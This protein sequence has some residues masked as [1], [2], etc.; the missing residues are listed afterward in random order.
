PWVRV[1]PHRVLLALG[2]MT[3]VISMWISNTTATALM[4]PVALGLLATLRDAH[5]PGDGMDKSGYPI[6]M[7]LTLSY[8]ATAGG[9]ATIIGTP[10][11]LL[12]IG[13]LSQ[14]AGISI[15][16]LTWMGFG[17][18]L[19]ILMV[20]L[21]W[22]LLHWAYPTQAFGL[23]TLEQHLCAQRAQLGPWTKGQF[24]ACFAFGAAVLL[25]IGPGLIAAV[26]G[27]ASPLASWLETHLPNELV[28]L[29]TAGL[30][31]ILPVNLR[32]GD[33]T[34]SWKQATAI[35]WGTILLFGGGLAFG[36]LMVKTG[37]ST[38]LGHG[39]VAWFGV[40]TVWSL[41]AVSILAA[42]AISEL[43]SNT[44]SASMLIPVVIAIAQSAEVPVIPPALG[45]C[46][47]ASLG[48]AL[49]V[50]TPPNAIVYGTG[51]VPIR[52]MVRTGLLFDLLGSIL[53]WLTLRLLCP[54]LGLA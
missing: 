47:G 44:A 51:L 15:S 25:W 49:P 24:N 42:V 53:I 46:L 8:A 19:A 26:W 20:L 52:S 3:A 30:L 13:L 36:E 11:N 32:T 5:T 6:A 41:T 45:A 27:H 38:V 18:P 50:S 7:M 4:L 12:G 22:A 43:A 54:V 17:L 39:F 33:F 14:Q 34:L 35:N 28:A 16:F 29:L 9:L 2:T 31:F 10:P 21:G 48:F 40:E 23:S 1:S 37:L